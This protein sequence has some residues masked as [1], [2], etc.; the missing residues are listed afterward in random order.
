MGYSP[1]QGV[2]FVNI[3]TGNTAPFTLKGGN[4]AIIATATFGG[5]N[6]QLQALALDG[7][8]WINVGSSI[9]AAGLSTLQL[10]AGQFRLSVTTATA[11]F[12]AIDSI[13]TG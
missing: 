8:T 12:V 3:G 10:P 1:T 6:I 9:T 5:G 13:P 2:A 11:C 4:F 7:S